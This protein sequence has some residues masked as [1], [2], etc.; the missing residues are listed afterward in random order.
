QFALVI[1]IVDEVTSWEPDPV[2]YSPTIPHVVDGEYQGEISQEK[3]EVQ[4]DKAIRHQQWVS[5]LLHAVGFAWLIHKLFLFQWLRLVGKYL[6]AEHVA[7]G[8][9]WGLWLIFL[10]GFGTALWFVLA[11]WQQW[12]RTGPTAIGLLTGLPLAC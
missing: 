2:Q 9:L 1:Y 6:G 11:P 5:L 7:H 3:A 10:L 12:F 4:F 8:A